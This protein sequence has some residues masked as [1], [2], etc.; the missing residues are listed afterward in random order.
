MSV[1]IVMTL[2]CGIIITV[3][4][5]YITYVIALDTISLVLFSHGDV[6]VSLFLMMNCISTYTMH[7]EQGCCI[8]FQVFVIELQQTH[9]FTMGFSAS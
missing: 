7:G 1:C 2:V 4:C 5:M 6:I 9:S 8:L 3:I